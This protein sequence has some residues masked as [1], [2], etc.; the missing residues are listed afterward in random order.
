MDVIELKGEHTCNH[1][2]HA[3]RIEVETAPV[4]H[5][6]LLPTDH[7]NMPAWYKARAHTCSCGATID[8]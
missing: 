4:E 1:R 3:S 7:S 5:V 2:W 6:C 8:V